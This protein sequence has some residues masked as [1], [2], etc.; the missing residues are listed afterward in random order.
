MTNSSLF[1]VL[2][3]VFG[4]L[5][6]NSYNFLIVSPVYG[7][8]H[9]KCMAVM[10]NQLADAGHNVTYFQ[11]FVVE[12]YQ[13]HDLIKN[14]KI[15]VINYFHDELGRENIRDHAVLKDAWYSAKYQSDLGRRTL[16]RKILYPT[17]EHIGAGRIF[18]NR[19]RN[20]LS[21]QTTSS[22]L[23]ANAMI[24]FER[25]NDCEEDYG[26]IEDEEVAENSPIDS[27][28][29][30]NYE[31]GDFNN[32]EEDDMEFEEFGSS[33]PGPSFFFGAGD[34]NDATRN[35]IL[36][37]QKRI[38]KRVVKSDISAPATRRRRV[39]KEN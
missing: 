11:P 37:S 5:N 7:F 39:N 13:N 28:L 12:M 24:G 16:V 38:S 32:V 10:A 33:L 8:S 4:I 19:L 30:P 23:L 35:K 2:F 20:R 31:M 21:V 14:P 6:V 29:G 18:S 15:E 25:I 27:D 22:I 36:R 17:F 9:M 26:I 3:L 34:S 1:I